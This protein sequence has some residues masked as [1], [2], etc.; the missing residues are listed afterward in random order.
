MFFNNKK[1][2]DIS[3]TDVNTVENNEIST[4]NINEKLNAN[5]DINNEKKEP[6]LLIFKFQLANFQFC[7][8]KTISYG[9][10]Q[11]LTKFNDENLKNMS[12]RDFIVFDMNTFKIDL[13]LTDKLN[14]YLTLL[15]KSPNPIYVFNI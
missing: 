3:T 11:I 7:I 14:A 2:N 10:K 8:Q 13:L 6:N 1:I 15:I 12:Y 9:E 4:I 5:N